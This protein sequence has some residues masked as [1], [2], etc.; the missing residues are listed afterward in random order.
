MLYQRMGQELT[1]SMKRVLIVEDEFIIA[2]D[3]KSRAIINIDSSRF[4][5]AM[6]T[7]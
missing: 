5:L 2:A 3:E 7:I 6:Q 1:G 4:R